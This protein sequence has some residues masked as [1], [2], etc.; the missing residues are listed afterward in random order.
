M[1]WVLGMVNL[2]DSSRGIFFCVADRRAE[3]LTLIIKAYV[4]DGATIA[5]DCWRGYELLARNGY[6]HL[7]VNHSRNFVDPRTGGLNCTGCRLNGTICM[8]VIVVS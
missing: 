5:T 2:D 1:V 8:I 6:T 4:Q 3:T 7:T